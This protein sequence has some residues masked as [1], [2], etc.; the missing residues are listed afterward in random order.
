MNLLGLRKLCKTT[1][2]TL[3]N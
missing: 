2:I 3:E 1:K